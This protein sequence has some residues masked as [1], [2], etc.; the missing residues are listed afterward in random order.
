[1]NPNMKNAYSEQG[2]FEI[3]QQLGTNATLERGLSAPARPAS[4]HF[5]ESERAHPA[6]RSGTNNG[7]R[8]NPTYGNDSQYS[9]LADSHYDGLH[10]S[11]VQRPVRWGNF[12]VS[13]TYSK[14]LD[15]VSEFFFSAPDQQFQYLAG[16]RPLGRRSARPPGVRRHDSFLARQGQH[17]VGALQPRIPVHHFAAVLLAAAVQHHHRREHHSGHLGAPDH[18]RSLHQSQRGRRATLS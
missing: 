9:S 16:L 2:S 6:P 17:A 14:A 5:R 15:D 3:E 1:M 10:V 4:D 8:P 7:C 11:F 13:Y 18:Q 12:R